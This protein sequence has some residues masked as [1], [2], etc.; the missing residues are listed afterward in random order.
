MSA[1]TPVNYS[2][3]ATQCLGLRLYVGISYLPHQRSGV[4]EPQYIYPPVLDPCPSPHAANLNLAPMRLPIAPSGHGALRHCL[5]SSDD[6]IAKPCPQPAR[7]DSDRTADKFSEESILSI[8]MQL[9][10]FDPHGAPTKD[11]ENCLPS[12]DA[13][14]L[15]ADHFCIPSHHPRLMWRICFGLLR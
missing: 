7:P 11:P 13:S 10:P 15:R 1:L 8:S 2:C 3:C 14:R 4:M 9:D 6:N 5:L 12:D